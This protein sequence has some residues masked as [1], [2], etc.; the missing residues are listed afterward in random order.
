VRVALV[1]AG[2]AAQSYAARIAEEPRLELAGAVDVSAG[3][4]AALVAQHG[5]TEYA[6]LD[7]L[8]ADN[9]VDAVVNL[10]PASSHVVV[11][12]AALEAGKH[13][14]TEKPVA[15]TADDARR[16]ARLA[17]DRG[18]RLSCAP[19]TLLGE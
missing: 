15:L 17:D 11:T 3:R 6:S 2:V 12:S 13:V 10:T 4:A 19:A 14:H 18:V 9:G 16:L 5:G 8:L 7:A 1:G